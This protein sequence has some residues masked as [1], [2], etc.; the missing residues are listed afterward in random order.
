MRSLGKFRDFDRLRHHLLGIVHPTCAKIRLRRAA[1]NEVADDAVFRALHQGCIFLVPGNRFVHVVTLHGRA[2]GRVNRPY[3]QN[4]LIQ[5]LG[6]CPTALGV[7]ARRVYVTQIRRNDRDH[8]VKP[9]CKPDFTDL[10]GEVRN[11]D[12]ATCAPPVD[13][14][15]RAAPARW[16]IGPGYPCERTTLAPNSRS[17]SA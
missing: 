4:Q 14:P 16:E 11:A 17:R 2:S 13:R 6:T 3:R 12:C 1:E 5:L 8:R 15:C 10:P 9:G 7:F